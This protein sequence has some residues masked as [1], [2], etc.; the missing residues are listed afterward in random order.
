MTLQEM[1]ERRT[2]TNADERPLISERTSKSLRLQATR[3]HVYRDRLTNNHRIRR[4][5][6][7]D[8][9]LDLDRSEDEEGGSETTQVYEL[10]G[11]P[12]GARLGHNLYEAYER[13]I[14]DAGQD[15]FQ[16]FSSSATTAPIERV[17]SPRPLSPPLRSLRSVGANLTRQNSVRRPPRPR[18]LDFNEFTTR[19][20]HI[21]RS[22]SEQA[23]SGEM[24]RAED[25]TWRFSPS[26]RARPTVTAP[27]VYRAPRRFFPLAALA[28][29][30]NGGE[31]DDPAG[32]DTTGG[33]TP[34]AYDSFGRDYLASLDPA[35]ATSGRSVVPPRLRRG[36]L[37]APESL[38]PWAA[39][40]AG[41]SSH[42][43]ASTH[44]EGPARNSSSVTLLYESLSSRRRDSGPEPT[45]NDQ[46]AH[47]LLTPRSNTPGEENA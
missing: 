23:S 28:D 39:N 45:E 17:T 22:N 19:R 26:D 37:R 44:P 21:H 9:L 46:E 43:A 2:R 42:D 13:T 3:N 24:L 31:P 27:P 32:S 7:H 35:P 33:L 25:G 11:V 10:G 36:G 5:T 14:S 6:A 20:R 47:Q 30:H 29:S 1:A 41:P 40:S 18:T 15:M 16:E 8:F 38:L 4:M 34:D 12:E